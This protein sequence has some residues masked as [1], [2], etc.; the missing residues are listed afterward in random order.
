M[1]MKKIQKPARKFELTVLT[2]RNLTPITGGAA[3]KF[4]RDTAQPSVCTVSC[5]PPKSDGCYTENH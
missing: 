1:T 4:P 5:L 3:Q 2:L